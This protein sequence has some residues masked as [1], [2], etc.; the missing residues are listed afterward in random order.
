MA[1]QPL[2]N[3]DPR[4]N[5]RTKLNENITELYGAM[6]T[7][8]FNR[9]FSAELLFDKN[10]I[11]VEEHT[12]TE[13]I[14]FTIAS[15]GNL[16]DQESWIRMQIITDGT[17]RVTFNGPKYLYPTNLNGSIP[18]EGTHQVI[19]FYLN[20]VATISWP[21][22]TSEVAL[23]TP[24]EA[25]TDFVLTPG[26]GDS[27]TEIDATW[28][29]KANYSGQ[30]I[31]LSS[32]GGDGPWTLPIELG[33]AASSYTRTGLD[34]GTTYHQRIRGIGNGTSFSN[35]LWTV[36]AT[37]TENAGDEDG[38]IATASIADSATDIPV[39]QELVWNFDEPVRKVGGAEI[40]N[41]NAG[42]VIKLKQTDGSGAD[43]PRTFIVNSSKTQI[44]VIPNVIYGANQ[45][46][47]SEVDGIEDVNG[48]AIDSAESVTFTTSA[49]TL[50]SFN[51]LNFG[52]VL[53]DLFSA[54][55]T[56][57]KLSVT[58]EDLVTSGSN[59]F[60]F[61]KWAGGLHQT[62]LFEQI[63]NHLTFAYYGPTSMRKIRFNNALDS[64]SVFELEYFGAIDTSN[65]LD[66]A[67]LTVDSV[68]HT[69]KALIE[70]VGS[71]PFVLNSSPSAPL[72]TGPVEALV[73]DIIIYSAGDT[74][75]LN[76]PIMR[77][78][79]D[80]SGNNYDGTWV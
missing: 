62:F 65:G 54:N 29:P 64:G 74:V 31:E 71:F 53:D 37:T 73:K 28:T 72:R 33:A 56:Y 17:H 70:Q 27:E 67:V 80:V 59:R 10:V 42:D 61:R 12:L 11:D 75:E 46:V 45:Q 52:N 41:A 63:N 8:E 21:E 40:T 44:R 1:Q 48:N 22:P 38:P 9:A 20:G 26:A 60:I 30:V 43:I 13:D 79:E 57:F 24:L 55:D 19:A 39:N 66:R 47:F 51:H 77:T 49:F 23:L 6:V 14:E 3:L 58:F 32:T 76:V 4:G 50:T 2:N 18:S 7:R 68:E 69:D 36:G 15:I 5:F 25:P 78:G 16:E 35:S 34:A